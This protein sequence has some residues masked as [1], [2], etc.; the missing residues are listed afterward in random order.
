MHKK[1]NICQNAFHLLHMI[2]TMYLIL[3]STEEIIIN[4]YQL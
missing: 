1:M 4:W 2:K 3:K